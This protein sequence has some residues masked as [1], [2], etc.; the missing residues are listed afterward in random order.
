[1]RALSGYSVSEYPALFTDSRSV[2]PGE[3]R[4]TRVS[5]EKND[6]PV[7]FRNKQRHF[8]TNQ[9]ELF[10]KYTKKVT[11]FGLEV[12]TGKALSFGLEFIDKTGEKV[13]CLQM[14]IKF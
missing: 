1:M 5:C 13:F 4:Q 6:F 2:P 9:A 14:Q 12:S 7:C 8:T 10:P 11:R 3:R